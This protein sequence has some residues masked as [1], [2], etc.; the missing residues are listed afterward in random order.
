MKKIL[1]CLLISA[2]TLAC[3]EEGG[4]GTPSLVE[5]H[6]FIDGERFEPSPPQNSI[7]YVT[8]SYEAGVVD[9]TANR[10]T[11]HLMRST[12]TTASD[13]S[14]SIVFTYPTAG[15][16]DGTYDFAPADFDPT[17]EVQ[18]VYS[19]GND[20]YGFSEGTI[21]VADLGNNK[22]RLSFTGAKILN[23]SGGNEEIPVTGYFE[24]IFT[25]E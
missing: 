15:D 8:T 14:M 16:L 1:L 22:Y 25:E 12:G 11:F 20:S 24:G 2:A 10:R 21:T 5:S 23:F 9:G 17:N 7:S 18:A 6:I 19:E 3:S 4:N 13:K